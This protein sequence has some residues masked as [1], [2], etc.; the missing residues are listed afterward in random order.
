MCPA[1]HG[2]CSPAKLFALPWIPQCRRWVQEV[3]APHCHCSV[4]QNYI[5]CK[6]SV[7][8]RPLISVAVGEVSKLKELLAAEDVDVDEKDEEGRTAL[9]V[10]GPALLELMPLHNIQCLR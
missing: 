8:H 4:H 10:Q 5:S 2:H 7:I 9:Q 3:L 1:W 6:P